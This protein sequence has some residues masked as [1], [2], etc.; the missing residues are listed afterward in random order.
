[1]HVILLLV[2]LG[3]CSPEPAVAGAKVAAP[4]ALA[5][6]PVAQVQFAPRAEVSGTL[7][8]IAAVQ[9]GFDVGGRIEA[10][11][12]ERGARVVA[13]QEIARLDTSMAEAQVAQAEGALAAASAQVAAA[14]AG[15]ERL[16]ALRAVGGVSPQQ[17]TDAD[18]GLQAA[19][20]G[21]QQAEA[22]ALLARTHRDHHRLRAPIAGVV[23]MGPD[24][25]GMMVG[26]G[27]PIFLVEDLSA[28]QLKTTVGDRETWIAAG[29]TATLRA[30]EG[31]G[32]QG[33]PGKVA[34]VLP[35]LDPATRRIPVEILVAGDPGP[36]RAHGYARATIEGG[37]ARPA[38]GVPASA[39]VARP[40]FC[41]FVQDE[42]G[43]RRVPVTVLEE[44]E[45]QLTVDGALA[46]GDAV[47]VAPPPG[48]GA[49]SS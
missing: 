11:L 45:G 23:T 7:E 48:L 34:R 42:A 46:A 16:Q 40:D 39:V 44:T 33:I 6:A 36:L 19:R 21:R 47:V 10:L 27:T 24:N 2:A 32:G 37:D 8:P 31:Q 14:E 38:W 17:E 28:L 1:V 18:A 43:P 5:T 9:L 12:V 41:V 20:A 49:S 29:Q 26:A 15:R 30:G 22:A 4:A 35:A 13:G 3:A 25:A